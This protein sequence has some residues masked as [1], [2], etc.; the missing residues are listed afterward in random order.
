MP[1]LESLVLVIGENHFPSVEVGGC[2]Y[3]ASPAA[4]CIA[5]VLGYVR[6]H[7]FWGTFPPI[8]CTVFVNEFKR[9]RH[10]CWILSFAPLIFLTLQ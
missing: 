8:S 4:L 5:P 10:C 2:L 1:G 3:F 7:I 6:L 9:Q